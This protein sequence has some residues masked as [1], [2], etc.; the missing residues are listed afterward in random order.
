MPPIRRLAAYVLA[1]SLALP[2]AAQD[3]YVIDGA[4]TT[5]MFEIAHN[6]GMSRQRGFFTNTAGRITLDRAAKTG[7][8]DVVIGTGS[9]VTGSRVLTD[10]LKRDDFFASDR[11]P[12][13][14]FTSRDV[15]FDGDVPVASRGELTLLD[16]TRPVT[17]AIADFRCGAQ[18]FTRRPMCGA[19]ATATIRRSDF[20]MTYGVPNVAGDDVRIV[21]PVEAVRE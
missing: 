1:L 14:R 13:M 15:T 19:E 20:G 4:H 18:L 2:A 12:T 8:I 16:V 10:V 9:I 17:L 5:P 11:Y 6:G 7:S 21:I 3:V